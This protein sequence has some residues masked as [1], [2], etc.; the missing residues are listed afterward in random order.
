[1]VRRY[2]ELAIVVVI[3]LGSVGAFLL[4]TSLANSRSEELD[5]IGGACCCA[6]ALVLCFH[7]IFQQHDF[8][9]TDSEEHE[10]S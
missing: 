6:L 2:R 3:T 8:P 7:L 4:Y 5:V 1:M 10:Q 9:E